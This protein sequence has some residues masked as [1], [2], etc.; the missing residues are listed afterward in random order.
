M[1]RAASFGDILR[2]GSK[3]EGEDEEDSP[4]V[5]KKSK[6]HMKVVKLFQTVHVSAENAEKYV[7]ALAKDGFDHK[8]KITQFL[9]EADLT[10]AGITSQGDVKVSKII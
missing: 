7:L 1:R 6:A 2:K 5:E 4:V 10:R 9:E 3:D 8:E